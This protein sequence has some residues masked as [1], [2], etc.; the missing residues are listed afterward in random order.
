MSDL[1]YARK[2]FWAEAGSVF[3]IVKDSY[4]FFTK[5]DLSSQIPNAAVDWEG[6]M[7]LVP[8]EASK[9]SNKDLNLDQLPRVYA[10]SQRDKLLSLGPYISNLGKSIANC[11]DT[12]DTST[13]TSTSSRVLVKNESQAFWIS[14]DQKMSPLLQEKLNKTLYLGLHWEKGRGTESLVNLPGPIYAR[15]YIQ[16]PQIFLWEWKSLQKIAS[17]K[18]HKIHK[19]HREDIYFLKLKILDLKSK[20]EDND[21]R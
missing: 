10:Q 19:I 8:I 15:T 9:F 21:I 4:F 2:A 7:P 6:S 18:I 16:V 11:L 12:K 3:F 14:L 1:I 5:K 17:S 13:I 20:Q